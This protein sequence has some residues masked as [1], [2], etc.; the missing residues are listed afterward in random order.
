[1]L[2][3][4]SLLRVLLG[5]GCPQAGQHP[6][7]GGGLRA[8]LFSALGESHLSACASPDTA[9]VEVS[10][11][12]HFL[13]KIQLVIIPGICPMSGRGIWSFAVSSASTESSLESPW[14]ATPPGNFSA[15]L[16]A[17]RWDS[18]KVTVWHCNLVFAFRMPT[19]LWTW[20]DLG[21]PSCPSQCG[22]ERSPVWPSRS[23]PSTS[24]TPGGLPGPICLGGSKLKKFFISDLI[25]CFESNYW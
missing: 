22:W 14:S 18:R 2:C 25:W 23:S 19:R 13:I 8:P 24:T 11:D 3:Q 10:P 4:L 6:G 7:E 9:G 12:L 17:S 21:W 20:S 16:S 15:T 1:M 5:R